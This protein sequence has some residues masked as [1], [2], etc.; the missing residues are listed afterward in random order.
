MA[1]LLWICFLVSID[2]LVKSEGTIIWDIARTT[3][4]QDAKAIQRSLDARTDAVVESLGNGRM[5]YSAI[6]TIGTPPQTLVVLID[7]GSAD[8]WI[9]DAT[10]TFCETIIAAGCPPGICE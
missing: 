10:P 8:V 3:H 7:T 2:S 4:E 1:F 9:P 6:V 5:K